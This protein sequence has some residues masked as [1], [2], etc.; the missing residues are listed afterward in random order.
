MSEHAKINDNGIL[1][2]AT[3]E[4]YTNTISKRQITAKNLRIEYKSSYNIL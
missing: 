1:K 4:S 2:W 3:K